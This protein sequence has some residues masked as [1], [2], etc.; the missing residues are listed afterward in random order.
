MGAEGLV[1]SVG[2]MEEW[3]EAMAEAEAVA[4]EAEGMAEEA[5]EMAMVAA[6]VEGLVG[7]PAGLAEGLEAE[8]LEAV[9]GLKAVEVAIRAEKQAGRAVE[10]AAAEAKATEG[11]VAPAEGQAEEAADLAANEAGDQAR[12]VAERDRAAAVDW[13]AVVLKGIL[14]REVEESEVAEAPA[15]AEMALEALAVEASAVEERVAGARVATE[16]SKGEARVVESM[17]GVATVAADWAIC[18]KHTG[19][20]KTNI[21]CPHFRPC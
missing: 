1:M 13:T 9:A 2:L 19:L 12:A 10:V 16:V 17:A 18:S 6:A 14:E 11:A 8:Q 15:V 21:G 4:A 7:P 3:A 20:K 5:G